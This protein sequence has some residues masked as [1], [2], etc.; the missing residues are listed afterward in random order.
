[1]FWKNQDTNWL[2]KQYH[3]FLVWDLMDQPVFTRTLEKCLNPIMGKS[4]VMYFRK[5]TNI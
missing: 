4:V 2:I 1:V 3:R 5:E